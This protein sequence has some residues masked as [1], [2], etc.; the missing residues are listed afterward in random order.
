[1]S[2]GTVG[3]IGLAAMS[4]VMLSGEES[5]L[6]AANVCGVVQDQT[7]A[8]IA[9]ANGI[10]RWPDLSRYKNEFRRAVLFQS[11]RTG[12]VCAH[13][14]GPRVPNELAKGSCAGRRIH[15]LGRLS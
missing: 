3:I 15:P 2:G 9:G 4:L 8:V 7:G 11:C 12:R 1:M 5:Q 14:S 10:E 13:T 6:P